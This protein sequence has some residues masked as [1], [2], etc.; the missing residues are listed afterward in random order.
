MKNFQRNS[1]KLIA[2]AGM[3][4]AAY[5]AL[6]ATIL[7]L[8]FGAV[9][10]RFAEML[11]LLAFIDPVYAIGVTLGCFISNLMFSEFGLADVII[12][13]VCTGLA[14]FCITKTKSL[15]AASLWPV[16]FTLPVAA[17]ITY[18]AELPF[19]PGFFMTAATV[20]AGEFVVVTVVGYPLFRYVIHPMFKHIA[21]KNE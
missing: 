7:P 14:T 19:Y 13:T 20:M 5:T 21:L 2:Y 6:T 4:A 8:S 15:F 3:T 10:F 1:V 11:N 16:L 18:F 9:Q 12:G 17:M